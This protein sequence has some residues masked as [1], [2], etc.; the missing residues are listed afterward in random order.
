MN[1]FLKSNNN[2]FVRILLSISIPLMLVLLALV[3]YLITVI[4]KIQ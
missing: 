4:L 1:I 3:F 2:T